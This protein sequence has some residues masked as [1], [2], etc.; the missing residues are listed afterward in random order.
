MAIYQSGLSL[1]HCHS[2]DYNIGHK[3]IRHANQ[4]FCQKGLP[5]LRSPLVLDMHCY[6]EDEEDRER[7]RS[8]RREAHLVAELCKTVEFD[9]L[10]HTECFSRSGLSFGS[11]RDRVVLPVR[12]SFWDPKFSLYKPPPLI[13]EETSVSTSTVP[14]FAE[15][16]FLTQ[17]PAPNFYKLPQAKVKVWPF[18]KYLSRPGIVDIN[19]NPG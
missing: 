7:K 14:R 13:K 11:R 1:V 15:N 10:K 2:I 4:P 6:L 9:S 19:S 8:Q 5:E 16:T 3:L 17:V 18:S 12:Q